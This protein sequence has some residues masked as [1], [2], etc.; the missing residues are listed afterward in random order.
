[1]DKELL[2]SYLI[3]CGCRES[4]NKTILNLEEEDTEDNYTNNTDN[5]INVK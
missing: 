4:D 5:V 2:R 1:M 3:S